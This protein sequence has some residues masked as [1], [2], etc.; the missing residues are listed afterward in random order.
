MN[1]KCGPIA[2]TELS[3]E[4][5]FQETLN[6]KIT[7]G[8]QQLYMI[9]L[10]DGLPTKELLLIFKKHLPPTLFIKLNKYMT[11][12]P[13]DIRCYI[14]W[15]TFESKLSKINLQPC[16]Q[17]LIHLLSEV[18]PSENYVKTFH[19]ENNHCST[20]ITEPTQTNTKDMIFTFYSAIY[21][22]NILASLVKFI[23]LHPIIDC[24]NSSQL[25][26]QKRGIFY[27][28]KKRLTEIVFECVLT[29]FNGSNYDNYL[30]CN[31]LIIIQSECKQRIRIFKKGSSISTIHCINKI[32]VTSKQGSDKKILYNKWIM[33]LF[34]KD[35]RNLVAS[36][37]SLD[38]IGQLFNLD[39]SKLCFPYEKAV[40]VKALK[41]MDSLRPHDDSFWKDT[42]SGKTSDLDSRL[43]AQ[44]FFNRKKCID[45]Y[46]FGTYYLTL[47]CL[48]LH[49]ILLTL[50]QTYLQ[51]SIDLFIRRNYSQSGLAYQQF[52]ILEPAKQISKL[53]AP[54]T[55]NHTVFNYMI[56]Q[57]VT[58]GLCTSFVHGTINQD[59]V[60]NEHLNYINDPKLDPNNWPNFNNLK[61][62]TKHFDQK[63]SG[64]STIDIRSLYP[65]ASL[66][67]LPVNTPL[68]YTRFTKTDFEELYPSNC[69]YKTLNLKKYC[70]RVQQNQHPQTD[71]FH[72]INRGPLFYNEYFALAHYLSSL[73]TNI[74]ILRFQSD[75]TAMGQ[76]KFTVY[77]IDGFL[78]YR[79]CTDNTIHIKLIQYHSVYYHGHT[80]HCHVKNSPSEI[81]K[82][83]KTHNVTQ[84]IKKLMNHFQQHFRALLKP[85][86]LEL[87]EISDCDFDHHQVPKSKNFI[88]PY[89]KTY[90][91][92][93]FL[94]SIYCKE[95]TG[96]I[97][98]KDLKI[99][100]NNQNP[101]FGF[102]IQRVEYDEKKLSP[103]TQEQLKRSLNLAQRVISLHESKSFMVISTD[104][105]NWLKHT[106]G[107]QQE[108]VIYHGLFFQLDSY[109][110]TSIE[111][112][113]I[114]RKELKNLLKHETNP[115]KKQN[116]EVK[117]ELIKLM[118]NSCYGYTLCNLS[119]S[120]FKIFEN[121]CKIPTK[122]NNIK[123]IFKF[124]ERIFLIETVKS[125][126]E[127]FPT[128]LG[129]I[130]SAILFQSKIILLKRLYFLLRYLNPRYA[131][132]LYMDTDSAHFLL[133]Y[134]RFEDNV[135][136]NLKSVFKSLF[137]KHF[138][139]GSKISGIWVEEGFYEL[140]EYLGEKCYRLYNKN[141]DKYLTHM[142]GMNSKFQKQYHTENVDLQKTPYLAYNIFFKSPDF[143]LFK[144]HMCKDLFTNYVPNK[145]YFVSASGSLPLKM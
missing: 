94:H 40:S 54:K 124:E 104:Y 83:N 27:N 125:I 29:A 89:N 101:L 127:S 14:H 122:I 42:F 115:L 71:R 65:S 10:Y 28:M 53:L 77:P 66:K 117:A 1:K 134:P 35:I 81:E 62:W 60:I 87:I 91:N 57:A 38:K 56:K 6:R 137:N 37:M 140:A 145:R 126:E 130:G 30:I 136:H 119:S 48:L 92:S 143:V 72:L 34:I 59:T 22:R 123:S 24:F 23:L 2:D 73:P 36:N 12:S 46:D 51:D 142:K 9:G 11:S 16:S 129:H 49:K 121:R 69:Y 138:E 96:L 97:V 108:P 17:D 118:V 39:V 80:D 31:H 86:T 47:D 45:V 20:S 109:L 75:F 3:F 95:L 98:V 8:I 131:Q 15:T 52:F 58:G 50:I 135:D 100:I 63:P 61:P 74:E 4:N 85:I 106:F 132:L 5:V 44:A 18:V 103:Y 144:T 84:E 26:P 128:L 79:T 99:K 55:I 76:L 21:Q 102:I 93:S 41:N 120:K 7:T 90:S 88:F 32:N 133:K 107:F 78:S 70:S 110:R 43:E 19:I 113:L 25:C 13:Q 111:N 105:L 116:Y 141:N 64:I 82:K 67:K 112:K 33:K 139:T 114:A 68:F